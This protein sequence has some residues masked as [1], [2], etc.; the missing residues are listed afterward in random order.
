ME[1]EGKLDECGP[2]GADLNRLME[3]SELLKVT[4]NI[5]FSHF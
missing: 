1:Q 5:Y 2:I 4:I 3:Q